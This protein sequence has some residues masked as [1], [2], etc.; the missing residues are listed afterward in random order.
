MMEVRS[1]VEMGK[2][3]LEAAWLV[4]LHSTLRAYMMDGRIEGVVIFGV[5]VDRFCRVKALVGSEDA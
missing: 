2:V 5:T 4:D 1:W 3:E